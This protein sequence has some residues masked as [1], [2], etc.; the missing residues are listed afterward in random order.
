MALY[1]VQGL[2]PMAEQFHERGIVALWWGDP[3]EEGFLELHRRGFSTCESHV[4]TFE[5]PHKGGSSASTGYVA[6]KAR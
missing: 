3:P 4:V 1:S 5:N 2:W 6:T